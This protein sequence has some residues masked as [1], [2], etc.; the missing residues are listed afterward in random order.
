LLDGV[1]YT[2]ASGLNQTP[3][4][5]SG[6]LLG[7]DALREFNVL[8]DTYGA[9]YGKRPGGQ[10]LMVANSGSNEL[11]GTVYE[12]LRNSA[13]D[14]RNYFDQGAIPEFQRNQFGGEL[15]GPLRHN[16]SFLFGNY[17]GFRQHLDLSDVTLVP[18]NNARNGYLPETNGALAYV[19]VAPATNPY[20]ALW[21][22]ANGPELGGGIAESFSHPQQTIREDFGMVRMDQYLTGRESLSATYFGGRQLG[23]YTYAK[24]LHA[25]LGKYA[26]AGG[27]CARN[28]CLLAPSG[29]PGNARIFPRPLLFHQ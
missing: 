9:A 25:G 2:G 24:S 28:T 11:H 5:T 26:R 13:M 4:G 10:V 15:G 14:A 17:E 8:T 29:E 12:Y 7:V 20:L 22:V 19:G 21:P 3:G 16:R 27:E 1:E 18:D 6:L 23:Q